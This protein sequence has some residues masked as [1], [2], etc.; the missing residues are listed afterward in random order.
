MWS[1]LQLVWFI[2]SVQTPASVK[3]LAITPNQYSAKVTLNIETSELP[4]SFITQINVYLNGQKIKTVTQRSCNAFKITG[5]IL[6]RQILNAQVTERIGSENNSRM[7]LWPKRLNPLD[8][9]RVCMLDVYQNNHG[10][11]YES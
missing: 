1:I 11:S 7:A 5:L 10:V 9:K 2:F 6:L 8:V 3:D 4:S